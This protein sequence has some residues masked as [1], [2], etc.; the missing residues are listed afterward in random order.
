MIDFKKAIVSGGA[1]ISDTVFSFDRDAYVNA[2][3]L[4]GCIR[5]QW[6]DKH[7]TEPDADHVEYWGYANRGTHGERYLVDALLADGQPLK[8][9]GN[10]QESIQSGDFSA[11]PDGFIITN[12]G[13][14]GVEFKT[15]DPR[16][17]K[18]NLP[19]A[20]HVL[21]IQLAMAL[22]AETTALPPLG[23]TI[24]YMDASNY[25]DI[26]ECYVAFDQDVVKKNERRAAQILRAANVNSL[27]RE[28]KTSGECK[29]FNCPFVGSCGVELPA[30]K[31]ARRGNRGSKLDQA[32]QAYVDCK[33]AGEAVKEG[34][35]EA[36]EAIKVEMTQRKV[37]FIKVGAYTA[38]YE[39]IAGRTTYDTKKMKADGVKIDAYKKV[40]K[41]SER[42]T[43]KAV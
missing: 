4:G 19:R 3:E 28:G 12:L 11:T 32:M 27:D 17:N 42:L 25:N 21:Q 16:T 1:V 24:I 20:R 9:A 26:T 29:S 6:F 23:G 31:A 38:T 36:R 33:T 8:F 18:A 39:A 34:L 43:I 30:E 35:E 37:T 7:G 5:R 41:A 22:F 40:G 13:F 15:I 10:D 2:S 14:H